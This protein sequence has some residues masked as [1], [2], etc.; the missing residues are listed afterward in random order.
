MKIQLYKINFEIVITNLPSDGSLHVCGIEILKV[1]HYIENELKYKAFKDRWVNIHQL[2]E[3]MNLT[4]KL[5]K[6]DGL[7][8]TSS[9]H[10]CDNRKSEKDRCPNLSTLP[11]LL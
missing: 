7:T 2:R 8:F 1:L 11:G 10:S 6:I 3:K 4:I 5:L 9:G